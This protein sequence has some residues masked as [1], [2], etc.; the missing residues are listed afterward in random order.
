[1][2]APCCPEPTPDAIELRKYV[3]LESSYPEIDED[4]PDFEKIIDL[5]VGD[6]PDTLG[7]SF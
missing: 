5:I 1:M 7:I 3:E 6:T 2:T 4:L